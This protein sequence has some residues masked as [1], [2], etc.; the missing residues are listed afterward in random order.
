[1][2]VW[3]GGASSP[4]AQGGS[5]HTAAGLIFVVAVVAAFVCLCFAAAASWIVAALYFSGSFGESGGFGLKT[6]VKAIA[7]TVA[8]IGAFWLMQRERFSRIAASDIQQAPSFVRSPWGFLPAAFV[9]GLLFFTNL[10]RHP[11]PAPDE[12]HHLIVARNLAEHGAYASGLAPNLVWFDHYDSVGAPVI[13]LVAAAFEV[14][15]AGLEPARA[16]I[17]VFGVAL[18]VLIYFLYLPLYGVR[19]AGL[20]SFFSLTAY[21]TIYLSRSLYGEVPAL[22]FIVLGLLAWRRGL[23]TRGPR[24]MLAAA[25]VCF[26]L[27]VLTKAFMVVALL[28]VV[29]AYAFD[30]ATHRRIPVRGILLPALGTVLVLGV[31]R[32]VEFAARHLVAEQPSLA[33]YYRHSLTFGFEPIWANAGQIAVAI[34]VIFLGAAAL[35]LAVP[36]VFRDQYDPSLAVLLLMAPLLVF[37]FAFF[38]PMHLPR[39]LWYPAVIAATCCGPFVDRALT[40]RTTARQPF[41]IPARVALAGLVA[42]VY[43]VPSAAM[44]Q[45]TFAADQAGPDLAVARYLA[46]LPAD[47]RIATTYWPAERLVNFLLERPVAVLSSDT[48]AADYDIL[49]HSDRAAIAGIPADTDGGERFGHYVVYRRDATTERLASLGVQP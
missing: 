34:P 17:A 22:V 1:M 31:W 4:M 20:A 47:T 2:N 15:G 10:D 40:A 5:R 16:V 12:L 37:W 7:F 23:Q 14:G 11:W 26:G 18:V 39:Y 48:A 6:L 45:K 21:G 28:A 36:R 42:W 8:A 27:A 25:G 9:A 19:A 35:C 38:T 29:G 32:I 46:E 30:R 49:I 41:H 3:L 24:W 33:L 13:G 43:L 44:V